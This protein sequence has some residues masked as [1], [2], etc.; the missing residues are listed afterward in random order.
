L[1][2]WEGALFY[3][4]VKRSPCAFGFCV[5]LDCA[6]CLGG[7]KGLLFLLA[8]KRKRIQGNENIK[9]ILTKRELNF[10]I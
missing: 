10:I 9:K 5:R 2:V 3:P 1:W 6:G 4:S 8:S 7:K